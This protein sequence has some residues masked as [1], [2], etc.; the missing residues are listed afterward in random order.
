LEQLFTYRTDGSN[1]SVN[2]YKIRNLN[3]QHNALS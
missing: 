1:A 2:V 3:K